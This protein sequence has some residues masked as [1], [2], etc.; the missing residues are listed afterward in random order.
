MTA[1]NNSNQDRIDVENC[2]PKAAEG[3]MIVGRIE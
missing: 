3:G 2:L 1:Y